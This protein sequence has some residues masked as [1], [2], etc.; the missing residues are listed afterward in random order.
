MNKVKK[1]QRRKI[2]ARRILLLHL[3]RTEG[4]AFSDFNMKKSLIKTSVWYSIGF[5]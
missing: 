4:R 5:S 1:P 2:N 3:G